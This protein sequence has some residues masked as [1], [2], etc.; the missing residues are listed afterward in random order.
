MT[1]STVAGACVRLIE[2]AD[3]LLQRKLDQHELVTVQD[4]RHLAVLRLRQLVGDLD[5]AITALIMVPATR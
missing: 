2:A 4:A 5:P 1:L 3:V